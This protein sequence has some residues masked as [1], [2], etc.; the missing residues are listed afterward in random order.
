MTTLS[1]YAL[2]R[3]ACG[4]VLSIKENTVELPYRFLEWLS[5]SRGKLF[6]MMLERG[7]QA[8]KGQP[9]HL[10]VMATVDQDSGK[11]NLATKG[12]GPLPRPERLSAATKA[13]EASRHSSD[14]GER[15]A[16]ARY[17]YANPKTFEPTLL[18][19]LEIFEGKSYQNLQKD[20]RASLLFTGEPPEYPS[21][22]FNGIITIVRPPDPYYEF[23]LQARKLFGHDPFHISQT[24][25]PWGYLFRPTEILVKTPFSRS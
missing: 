16:S 19:G 14:L 23:L 24:N 9:S 11:V 10:A 1:D 8:I 5:S 17:F 15:I 21:Y 2:N 6:D 4:T 7:P 3:V 20:P 18:G 13:F 25:Y 12:W 22:Q